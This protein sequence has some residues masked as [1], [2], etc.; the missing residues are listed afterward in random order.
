MNWTEQTAL[1]IRAG[2]HG[3]TS[4]LAVRV[5][6]AVAVIPSMRL[7]LATTL[8][9]GALAATS[10][11]TPHPAAAATAYT[12]NV[13]FGTANFTRIDDGTV[14]EGWFSYSTDTVAEV[15]GAFAAYTSAGAASAGYFPYRNFGTWGTN[16]SGCSADGVWWDSSSGATCVKRTW[17]QNTGIY[18]YTT[19]YLNSLLLCSSVNT[20]SCGTGYYKNNNVIKLTVH[21]GETIHVGVHMKDHDW[22]SADDEFCT[23]GENLGPFT[24]AQLLGMNEDHSLYMSHNG[25][26]ECYVTYRLSRW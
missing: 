2:V 4:A 26:A 11:L 15:Y 24:D 17:W 10:L 5:G 22:G 16:G 13:Y 3:M 7:R 8:G 14:Y 19:E 1:A 25:N 6:S 18:H 20:T 12:V 21:P 23:A 9:V